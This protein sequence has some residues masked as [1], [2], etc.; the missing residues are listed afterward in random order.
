MIRK[1]LL[2]MAL[3]VISFSVFAETTPYDITFTYPLAPEVPNDLHGYRFAVGYQPKALIWEKVRIYFDLSFGHWWVPGANVN[4]SISIYALAPM[5][6]YYVIKESFISPFIEFSVGPAYTT[7]TRID[8]RNLGM[9]FTFQD[10]LGVGFAFG[11]EQKLAVSL[12]ALHYSNA[13]TCAHNSGITV[14]LLLNINYLF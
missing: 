12:S 6:R 11:K 7:R 1:L 5:I 4:Q 10:Q 2:A 9:H 14:P 8:S 13:S 3:C